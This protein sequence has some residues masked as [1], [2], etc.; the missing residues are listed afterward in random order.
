MKASS[1]IRIGHALV[2]GFAFLAIA[3][4]NAA[5]ARADLIASYAT[6]K[7][8]DYSL[9]NNN[10][11]AGTTT[12]G[13]SGTVGDVIHSFISFVPPG[14]PAGPIAASMNLNATST[15]AAS[16]TGIGGTDK[17]GGFSGTYSI[18]GLSGS[19]AGV[20]LMSATFT[21][22]TLS[23]TDGGNT[24]GFSDSSALA[25]S[26]VVL[27][28]PFLSL[29]PPEEFNFSLTSLSVPL[30]V[31]GG[32]FTPFLASDTQDQSS[33]IVPEPSTMAIAGLGALGLI[34]Y[35]IRRRKGA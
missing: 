24:V 29:A 12:F 14:T 4:G 30:G 10:P 32:L 3:V 5:S 34:G 7:Q 23:G 20:T 25:G 1:R 21:G 19:Y 28:T 31:S 18:V 9:S 11:V 27:S 16:S 17:Q 15:S 33:T 6:G 22:A 2:A 13:T 8:N 35:G 26:T